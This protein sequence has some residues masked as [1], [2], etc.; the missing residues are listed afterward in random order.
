M[1]QPPG[2]FAERHVM[3]W[4]AL[5]ETQVRNLNCMAS[6]KPHQVSVKSAFPLNRCK[7]KRPIVLGAYRRNGKDM[8]LLVNL[9]VIKS[10]VLSFAIST[11]PWDEFYCDTKSALSFQPSEMV[12]LTFHTFLGCYNLSIELVLCIKNIIIFSP[13]GHYHLQRCYDAEK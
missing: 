1:A 10:I 6:H 7:D 9:L 12:R 11:V 3:K 8:S 4:D 5:S 2:S 13:P